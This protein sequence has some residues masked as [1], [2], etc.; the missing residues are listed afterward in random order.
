MNRRL[1]AASGLSCL[2]TGILFFGLL[3]IPFGVLF[4]VSFFLF[5]GSILLMLLSLMVACF[6]AKKRWISVLAVLPSTVFIVLTVITSII[7]VDYRILYFQGRPPT[8]TKAQWAEDLHFLADQMESKYPDLYARVSEEHFKNTVSEIESNILRMSATEITMAFFRLAALPNDAHTLPLF[9]LPPFNLHGLPIRIYGF[10][11]GWHIID[12]GRSHS[13]LIGARLERIGSTAIEDIFE[14]SLSYIAAESSTGQLERFTFLALIPEW[15]QT[16]GIIQSIQDVPLTVVRPDGELATIAIPPVASLGHI[17]WR[18]VRRIDNRL[19][20]VFEN[21]RKVTYQMELLEDSRTLYIQCNEVNREISEFSKRLLEFVSSHNFERTV[22]DLRNNLGGDDASLWR[23]VETIRNSEEINRKRKL[24]VLIGRHTFSSG[25]LLANRLQLQTKAIFLGEPTSQGPVFNANP[26]PVTLPNSGLLFVVSTTSTARTQPKWPFETGT[27]I[28]PDVYV[29]YT[30]NDFREGK[31]PVL[32]AALSYQAA[33]ERLATMA[34]NALAPYTG[35]YLLGSDHVLN[36]EL[37]EAA[38]RFTITDS[39]PK[40]LFRVQSD[41]YPVTERDFDTDIAGVHLRF[42]SP[43]G[44]QAP[45]VSL[46]W[47]GQEEVLLREPD[48]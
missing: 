23:F 4:N 28:R 24:F 19:P 20:S 6:K 26:T 27:E 7:S 22:I 25:V 29:R 3:R 21:R 41:L 17:Y 30:H 34:E 38:L 43:P 31:D 37:H 13:H 36:L 5:M 10:E 12:A 39:A 11:D 46:T 8:P 18:L 35:R 14:R 16:Q 45:H 1:I 42:P 32:E 48:D 33:E 47:M 2:V 9:P 40:S 15:L 44:L